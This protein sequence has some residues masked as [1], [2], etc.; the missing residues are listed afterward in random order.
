MILLD[1]E[2]P[3]MDGKET[4]KEIRKDEELKD[5]PVLFFTSVAIG[6]SITPELKQRGILS[7]D[8]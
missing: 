8:R 4:L 6:E 3:V 7:R 2:M 1:Y 5:I